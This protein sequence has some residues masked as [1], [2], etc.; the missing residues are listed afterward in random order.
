MRTKV[1]VLSLL[2]AT[3]LAFVAMLSAAQPA[4]VHAAGRALPEEQEGR[5][6]FLFSSV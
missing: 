2:G 4:L 1:L 3:S 5:I 6:I